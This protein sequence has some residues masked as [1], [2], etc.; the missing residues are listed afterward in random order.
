ME[1]RPGS[2]KDDQSTF[3]WLNNDGSI[4]YKLSP[5]SFDELEQ[6]VK[7]EVQ[8]NS[9]MQFVVSIYEGKIDERVN[10]EKEILKR[11]GDP[12]VT[13]ASFHEEKVTDSNGKLISRGF[14]KPMEIK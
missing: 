1:D 10:K 13:Y 12:K 5:V 14:L 9:K 6:R 4:S 11:N 7:S 2:K 8:K 3:I